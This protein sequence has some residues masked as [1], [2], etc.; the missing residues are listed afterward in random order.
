M[1]TG[2]V[3]QFSYGKLER[4]SVHSFKSVTPPISHVLKKKGPC[5]H[6]LCDHLMF[7]SMMIMKVKFDSSFIFLH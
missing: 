7:S 3:M 2:N 5:E 1:L 6:L 4:R